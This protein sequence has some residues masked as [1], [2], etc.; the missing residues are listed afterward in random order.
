MAPV[1]RL[2]VYAAILDIGAVPTFTPHD[3]ASA[4]R[5]VEACRQAGVRA[6]EITNRESGTYE[7]FRELTPLVS[8]EQPEMI[9][10]VGTIYDA[11]TAAL[12]IAAGAG[13]VVSPVLNADVARLCNRRRVAYLP[14]CG[15][16]SEISEAEELGVEIVKLFP[17]AAFNGPAFVRGILGPSPRSRIMPTNVEATKEATEAWFYAGVAC[18]GVGPALISDALQ[19]EADPTLLTSRVAE[20]IGWISAARTGS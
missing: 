6:I 9:L 3:L 16:A 15:T 12:F 2:A 11:P 19:E 20:Y 1:D 5:V 10:G 14:G 18:V 4:R 17:A 7:L 8:G 13:F